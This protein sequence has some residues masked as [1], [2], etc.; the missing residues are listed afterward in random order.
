MVPIDS[1]TPTLA[2]YAAAHG[3]PHRTASLALPKATQ[4]MRHGFLQEVRSVAQ[5][6]LPGGLHGWLAQLDYAYEGRTDIERSPFTVVLTEAAASAGYA[7]RVLCHDRDLSK[8]DRA[9]PD[10]DRQVVKLDDRGVRLESD[11]FLA[12]YAVSTDADQDQLAVWQLFSPTLIDWL[13][14]EAPADFSFELQDGALACFVPG[15]VA[16]PAAL[17][18]LCAGA[19]RVFS[20][21]GQIDGDGRPRTPAIAGEGTRGDVIDRELAAHPFATPPKS[22]KTAAK[23]FRS[24]L[25]L[26]HHAWA[27]G[28][29]AF[30]RAHAA[31]LGFTPLDPSAF[32]AGHLT[33]ALPG[34]LGQV[35]TGRLSAAD[36]EAFLVLTDS[37]DFDDMGWSNLVVDLDSPLRGLALA[38]QTPRG[39]STVR[40]SLMVGTDGRS[41]IISA[42]DG[43]PRD[44][45]GAELEAF[46]AAARDLVAGGPG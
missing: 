23:A 24:G 20:R 9:N 29:E 30:F 17:D 44:R 34:L 32:R 39:D 12:R 31:A 21:V 13:T 35:A 25:L 18:A 2:D 7:I 6:E 27:L 46:F 16:E 4:L 8:R 10:A 41:L 15:Y 19:A 28:A 36:P 42:L 43:G 3:L 37:E 40:G 22:V 33:T 38:Q 45:S 11:G 1:S 26:G 5:G 14:R